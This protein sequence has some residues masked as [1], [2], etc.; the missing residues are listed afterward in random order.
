MGLLDK[1]FSRAKPQPVQHNK[2]AIEQEYK[3]LKV[4]HE[5]VTQLFT[6]SLALYAQS[7]MCA[8]PRFQQI[9]GINCSATGNSFRCHETELLISM[10]RPY[11]EVAASAFTDEVTNEKWTCKTCGSEYEYGWSDFS[12][13]IDR[14]KLALTALKT[15]LTGLP[16]TLPIPLYMGLVGHSYPSRQQM[17]PVSF[18]VFQKYMTEQ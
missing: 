12:I 10:I 13:H 16:A 1:L 15:P 2:E 4:K 17:A 3:D 5:E 11:F 7:C 6:Q 9:V 8:Y 18:E 14:Q